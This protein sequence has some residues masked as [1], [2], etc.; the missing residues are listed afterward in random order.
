MKKVNSKKLVETYYEN[1]I[2]YK[3]LF[4]KIDKPRE[5]LKEKFS[6]FVL[7]QDSASDDFKKVAKELFI[8]RSIKFSDIIFYKDKFLKACDLHILT[9]EEKLSDEVSKEYV[10]LN[11]TEYKPFFQVINGNFVES[12]KTDINNIP[13]EEFDKV[14]KQI[15]YE[16]NN[17]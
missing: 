16:Y 17:S 4:K 5:Q 6:P 10:K 14:L 15:T 9:N 1:Y 7:E 3:N 8:D 2:S 11:R 12:K 13:Q